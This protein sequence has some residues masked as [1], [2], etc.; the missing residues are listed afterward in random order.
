MTQTVQTGDHSLTRAAE[1]PLENMPLLTGKPIFVTVAEGAATLYGRV[2]QRAEASAAEDAVLAVAGIHAVAQRV[3]VS[4][5]SIT[6]TDIAQ[7][8]ARALRNAPHVPE[9][10]SATVH[11][12]T[13]V[14]VGEVNWQYET[15]AACRAVDELAGV[16]AV[17]CEL[18]VLAG[19]IAAQ[20][21]YDIV[22][23]LTRSEPLSQ[24]RLAVT[25]NGRG[26]IVLEGILPSD[27]SRL[28]AQELCWAVPGV[29]SVTSHVIV[30]SQPGAGGTN[31]HDD[32]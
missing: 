12:H 15:E 22:V 26:A 17:V 28:E 32:R 5:S 10:V 18:L 16:C 25:T 2:H 14:L 30:D 7:A 8:A 3:Q 11:G 27:R 29:T 4:D 21:E 23:A 13:L 20:L 19:S 24:G 6:D 31:S 1:L 9:T